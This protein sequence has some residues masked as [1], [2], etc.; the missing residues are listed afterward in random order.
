MT[1]FGYSC[2]SITHVIIRIRLEYLSTLTPSYYPELPQALLN[3]CCTVPP[4]LELSVPFGDQQEPSRSLQQDRAGSG[5][6]LRT[7]S[8]ECNQHPQLSSSIHGG[9]RQAGVKDG[10]RASA[11]SSPD[12]SITPPDDIAASCPANSDDVL[13]IT[14]LAI[15]VAN[16]DGAAGEQHDIPPLELGEPFQ[17]WRTYW[18]TREQ[19][20]RP[21]SALRRPQNESSRQ[22]REAHENPRRWI[23][24]GVPTEAEEHPISPASS[25]SEY[26]SKKSRHLQSNCPDVE[27]S[28][29]S[30]RSFLRRST[31]LK[32][33]NSSSSSE[34]AEI[35]TATVQNLRRVRFPR[36]AGNGHYVDFNNLGPVES[37]PSS[38]PVVHARVIDIKPR[39]RRSSSTP[40][41]AVLAHRDSVEEPQLESSP[42]TWEDAIAAAD[43]RYEAEHGTKHSSSSREVAVAATQRFEMAD[44]R[45]RAGKVIRGRRA[46]GELPAPEAPVKGRRLTI[47]EDGESVSL[48]VSPIPIDLNKAPRFATPSIHSHGSHFDESSPLCGLPRKVKHRQAPQESPR[49]KQRALSMQMIQPDKVSLRDR[50]VGWLRNVVSP[51]SETRPESASSP[52][53]FKVWSVSEA[54]AQSSKRQGRVFGS[55]DFG[56]LREHERM[57]NKQ[58]GRSGKAP[59]AKPA[60]KDVTNLRQP[61]YL[62][63]NSF[64]KE[65]KA[66]IPVDTPRSVVPNTS[67]SI[68]NIDMDS[69]ASVFAR[70]NWPNPFIQHPPSGNERNENVRAQLGDYTNEISLSPKKSLPSAGSRIPHEM[71]PKRGREAV[72]EDTLARLEGRVAPVQTS[73]LPS[74]LKSFAVPAPEQ[75]R[76]LNG[77]AREIRRQSSWSKVIQ[78][79]KATTGSV[80]SRTSIQPPVSAHSHRGLLD[81]PSHA[82]PGRGHWFYD[83]EKNYG[84]Q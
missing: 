9:P 11:E 74:Y 37:Q 14:S 3:A 2:G 10:G 38:A 69:S 68:E 17:A 27:H 59:S 79:W 64:S 80:G 49:Q 77:T 8:E 25:S 75:G 44:I 36:R 43:R 66:P 35:L 46:P 60:L 26:R 1:Y 72:I 47:R 55:E 39:R 20:N 32:G 58:L 6:P 82:T 61:G 67:G 18:Q 16:N 22:S 29:W 7:M 24:L 40:T 70:V 4:S 45:Q 63:H 57:P 52:R 84:Q 33:P 71:P 62:E 5:Y 15:R 53:P 73:P 12:L 81:G 21:P 30:P 13:D 31:A 76:S 23:E 48:S 78:D 54:A 56:V 51:G 41:T 34:D 28:S 42:E 65:S 19:E 50:I 83:A